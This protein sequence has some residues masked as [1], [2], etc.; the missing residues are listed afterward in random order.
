MTSLEIAQLPA[1]I[2]ALLELKG[3]K[4]FAV[5]YVDGYG[6]DIIEEHLSDELGKQHEFR[7]LV[8]LKS[9]GSRPEAIERLAMLSE[10]EQ[11]PSFECREFYIRGYGF[12]ILHSKLFISHTNDKVTFI[13][14]SHNLTKNALKRN[15]EHGLRVE[16]A[17]TDSVGEETLKEFN[18][19]WEDTRAV[20][21][22][23]ER[24]R[25]YASHF[26]SNES[27]GHK[28]K[29]ENPLPPPSP[30]PFL[31]PPTAQYWLLKANVARYTFQDL[32]AERDEKC[33]WHGVRQTTSNKCIRDDFRIGDRI[34]YYRSSPPH[35]DLPGI[36]GTARVVSER[37]PDPSA[38]DPESP[39]YD[40]SSNPDD[41]TWYMAEIQ[42]DIILDRIVTLPELRQE[43]DLASIDW[44]GVNYIL[45]IKAEE[46][47][48]VIA[49]G[50]A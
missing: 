32:L 43:P 50:S 3:S 19:L 25:Q 33:W 11:N 4:S 46:F 31:I 35:P 40:R 10:S 5:A 18:C 2:Q 14:G 1:D 15:K 38:W 45:P 28:D 16:S 30:N 17:A 22:T 23:A 44:G 27:S 37:E 41:P 20:A 12:A 6:V 13:T 9:C 34:L 7:L 48:A 24:A 47:S 29:L 49:M 42:A 8:D 21:L 39:N 26:D 36:V